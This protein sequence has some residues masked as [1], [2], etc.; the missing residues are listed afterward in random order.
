ME[1]ETAIFRRGPNVTLRPLNKATDLAPCHRWVNDPEVTRFLMHHSPVT[2]AE[3]ERWFDALP[4]PN[5]LI[6]AIDTA[7]GRFIGTMG[8]H[9]IDWRSGHA[10]SG[11]MIGEKEFWGK[12]YGTEAKMLLLDVAFNNLNLQRVSS[13]V[14]E[15]NPRSQRYS[16][17]CGYVVEGRKRRVHFRDGRYWDEI[18]MGVLKEDWLPLWQKFQEKLAEE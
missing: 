5:D 13:A 14:I 10:T 2:L 12:G 18:I 16:E 6:V 8:L 17:K 7:D 4:R 1:K 9:R 15:L 3:E 11:A